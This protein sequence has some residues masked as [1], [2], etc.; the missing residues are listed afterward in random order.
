M[1]GVTVLVYKIWRQDAPLAVRGSVLVLGALLLPPYLFIYDLSLLAL[2]LAWIAWDGHAR[3][4]SPMEK[5]LLLISWLIPML[6]ENIATKIN[7]PLIPLILLLLMFLALR[8]SGHGEN[9]H[10]PANGNRSWLR[11]LSG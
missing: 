9:G 2:P 5:W 10:W 8:R 7:L 3:G 4:F 1:L 11:T 6:A